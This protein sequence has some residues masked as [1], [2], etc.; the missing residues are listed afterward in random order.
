LLV[1]AVVAGMG[2]RALSLGDPL[3]PPGIAANNWIALGDRA[4]FVITNGDSLIGSTS[5]VGVAK[6][7][8]MLRRAGIWLRIDSAP[9]YDGAGPR[10]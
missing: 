3:V 8:F 5:S 4:G 2:P 9:D 7:Y 1:T 6:G 10:S